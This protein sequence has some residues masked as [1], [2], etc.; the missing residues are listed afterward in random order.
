MLVTPY[1]TSFM[2]LEEDRVHR[3]CA[4]L[5]PNP[6]AKSGHIDTYFRD[7]FRGIIM[8][9]NDFFSDHPKKQ[10]EIELG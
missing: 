10:T 4:S 1:Y 9:M 8:G 2:K 6:L 7:D 5:V 3:L